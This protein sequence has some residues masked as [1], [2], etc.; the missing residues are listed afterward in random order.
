VAYLDPERLADQVAGPLVPAV[1]WLEAMVP[2]APAAWPLPPEPPRAA[3]APH[4]G[5]AVQWFSFALVT[6]IG[7]TALLR[8]VAR[9]G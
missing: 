5:Y 7:Y 2:A 4:L 9:G 8:R 6:L 1:L 3:A